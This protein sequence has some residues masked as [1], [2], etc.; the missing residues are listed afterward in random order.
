MSHCCVCL[1][2]RHPY[3]VL[4]RLFVFNFSFL[5]GTRPLSGPSNDPNALV[6]FPPDGEC[7]NS[8]HSM[9]DMHLFEVMGSAAVAI[10][11][12]LENQMCRCQT[13]MNKI[14]GN[15]PMSIAAAQ[16]QISNLSSASVASM[17]NS[18]A[19][20][21]P[22]DDYTDRSSSAVQAPTSMVNNNSQKSAQ[23]VSSGHSSVAAIIGSNSIF[24]SPSSY[25]TMD[26]VSTTP[27]ANSIASG[28]QK[29]ILNI[30]NMKKGRSDIGRMR[31]R[32]GDLCLQ[33]GIFKVTCICFSSAVLVEGK[34]ANITFILFSQHDVL[35]LS[36][37][38]WLL[39][40]AG[41]IAC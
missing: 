22:Y 16:K 24:T 28:I 37:V 27:A 11:C 32:M 13:E 14:N 33:V 17:M 41:G 8:E 5:S 12:S 30:R 35:Y 34:N 7:G 26:I 21:T 1:C 39:L 19:L 9:I 10:M 29:D 3:V 20:M 25:T 31:K 6:V 23:S 36:C 38:V 18:L 4:R 2:R 40:Y 15:L